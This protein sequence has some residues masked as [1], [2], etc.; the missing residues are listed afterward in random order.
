[1]ELKDVITKQDLVD[2]AIAKKVEEIRAEKAKVNDKYQ[3][4]RKEREEA[5]TLISS[6]RKETESAYIQK[7]FAA[8]IKAIEKAT[9]STHIVATDKMEYPK[10]MGNDLRYS[11]QD[12]THGSD[13]IYIVFLAKVPKVKGS[14]QKDRKRSRMKMLKRGFHPMMMMD[15]HYHGGDRMSM[16]DMMM[17][18]FE[19][20]IRIDREDIK[21]AKIDKAVAKHAKLDQECKDLDNEMREFDTQINKVRNQKDQV[22]S[23]I[24]EQALEDSPEGK[25]MLESLQKIDFGNLKLL[26]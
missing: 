2:Y 26:S 22:K 11:L 4:K 20:M 10:T 23:V 3:A 16:G 9:N 17:G 18:P 13:D 14:N 19:S 8:A 21:N 5:L 6:L 24:I 7:N 25:K 12:L 1:M 15:M